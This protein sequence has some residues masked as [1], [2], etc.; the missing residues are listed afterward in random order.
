MESAAPAPAP[1]SEAEL[2]TSR[3]PVADELSRENT[4]SAMASAANWL[5]AQEQEETE[6]MTAK[7]VVQVS[8]S[9]IVE[10][11]EEVGGLLLKHAYLDRQKGAY[12]LAT[13]L[14]SYKLLLLEQKAM[15]DQAAEY[16]KGHP[17][18]PALLLLA[19]EAEGAAEYDSLTVQ[20][21][22]TCL[23]N[24]SF[25]GLAAQM[26]A[27]HPAL[28]QFV[29][30]SLLRG[31]DDESMLHFALPAAYNLSSESGMLHALD[32][33]EVT[34]MLV[35]ISKIV[36]PSREVIAR[37]SRHTLNNI[38]KYRSLQRS[39][40]SVA[41]RPAR[42]KG[43]LA[44]C[45]GKEEKESVAA[46]QEEV[47]ALK[48]ERDAAEAAATR[49]RATSHTASEVKMVK[50]SFLGSV[51]SRSGTKGE[52]SQKEA[53]KKEASKKKKEEEAKYASVATASSM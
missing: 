9:P 50:K 12:D 2:V 32:V 19:S 42:R 36:E 43:L 28:T 25:L 24:L 14:S 51:F 10:Q 4:G 45:L 38:K 30:R 49:E 5:S 29:V 8:V 7:E 16:L 6:E 31:R 41:N 22:L 33:A 1:A 52:A 34:P 47:A 13:V 37:Y 11:L 23:T 39:S 35:A 20:L 40:A 48:A 46:E 3:V 15:L 27:D 26:I 18:L 44:L 53:S 21:C 17:V